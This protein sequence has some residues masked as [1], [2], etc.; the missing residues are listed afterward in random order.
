MIGAL[1]VARTSFLPFMSSKVT[2][3]DAPDSLHSNVT[4]D[5]RKAILGPVSSGL[6]VDPS[7]HNTEIATDVTCLTILYC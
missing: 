7:A 5:F 2:G 1:L 3:G 6:R 4:V